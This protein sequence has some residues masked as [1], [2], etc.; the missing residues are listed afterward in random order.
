MKLEVK[1]G[2]TSKLI[3]VFIS[4][5]SVTTGAG[6]TGLVF[7]SPSLTAYYCRGGTAIAISLLTMTLGTWVSGGFV[8]VD[9]TNMTG[10]YQIGIPD[11]ALL[12]GVDVVSVHL[13]GAT[14]MAPVMCE[15]QLTDDDPIAS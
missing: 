6:L 10:L 2:T 12:T 7:N 9:G 3:H 13:K 4:D 5:S 15:I 14:N 8:A 1:K 11:A